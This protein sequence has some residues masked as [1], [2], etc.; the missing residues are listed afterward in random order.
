MHFS[1]DG[2][3]TLQFVSH[4]K[5]LRRWHDVESWIKG[6]KQNTKRMKTTPFLD[7]FAQI[8]IQMQETPRRRSMSKLRG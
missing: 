3:R 1:P 2:R 6:T 4:Q 8:D 5:I 7:S